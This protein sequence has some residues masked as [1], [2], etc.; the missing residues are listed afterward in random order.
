MPGRSS[1]KPKLWWMKTKPSEPTSSIPSPLP[2]SQRS[3]A[4]SRIWCDAALWIGETRHAELDPLWRACQES[5]D[6]IAVRASIAAAIAQP[7]R[8]EVSHVIVAQTNRHDARCQV[9]DTWIP[10][11]DSNE[12][13]VG[14]LTTVFPN[15]KLRVVHGAL[16]SPSVLLPASSGLGGSR[17]Q[18]SWIEAI[19]AAEAVADLPNW[20]G[21]ATAEVDNNEDAGGQGKPGVPATLIVVAANYCTAESTF[22][23][24]AAQ[25]R[26]AGLTVPAMIW[27]R[28]LVANPYRESAT[29]L[30][31]DTIACAASV[32]Q[33]RSRTAVAPGCHHVWMT[34]DATATQREAAIEG[35]VRA[36]VRKPGRLNALLEKLAAA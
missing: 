35:G 2:A 14:R 34:G 3:V 29:I 17:R 33:W 20:L 27:S 5:C 12:H 1:V 6:T 18:S 22:D 36:V 10:G 21:S 25:A 32:A 23:V 26:Q 28:T 7:P 24:I 30:W 4:E 15:A 8:V 19:S 11:R 9:I 13:P 16:V 31:D